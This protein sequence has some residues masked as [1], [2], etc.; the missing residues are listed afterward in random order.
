MAAMALSTA[1]EVCFQVEA[2][3]AMVLSMVSVRQKVD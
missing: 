2:T 1:V 3:A